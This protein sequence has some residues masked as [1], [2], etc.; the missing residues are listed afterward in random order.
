[1]NT[2]ALAKHYDRL[3]PGERL[4]LIMAASGR[5]DEL[6]RQRLV[7]S[8][9]RVCYRVPDHFGLAQAF[10]EVG[11][12]H[13]LELLSLSARYFQA[14]AL[15]DTP[16]GRD[17]ERLLDVAL[18]FGYLVKVQLAGWRTFCAGHDLP[19]DLC[20]S[21]LPGFATVKEAERRAGTAAFTAEG[22]AAYLRRKY[23][24]TPKVVTADEVAAGLRECLRARAEWWG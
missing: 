5:G 15:A 17:A 22:V 16:D 24:A 11:E 9:P 14:L 21:F 12:M 2:T 10:R 4:P 7:M 20:W 3:T 13:F 18:L 8:A 19:A 23:D 6:E 1:M